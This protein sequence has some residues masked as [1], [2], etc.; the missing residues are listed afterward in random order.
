MGEDRYIPA[1]GWRLLT[2]LFDPVVAVTTRERRWRG[3]VV[4]EALAPSPATILD[5]GCGTGTLA[6]QLA[7]RAPDTRVIGLDGDSDVL[8]RAAAKAQAA[9]VK[10]ELL[11]GMADSIPLA[12]ASIDCAVSTLVFHHLAP[13]T[14]RRA[15]EEI[16][17]VLRPGGRVVIADYGGPHDLLMRVAFLCVQLL[18]G[19]QSTR[20]HAAGE[21]PGLIADAGFEVETIDRLRTLS[22]TLELLTATPS[23]PP[24]KDGMATNATAVSS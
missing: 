5:V 21:L 1:A 12:D 3:K 19:F 6:V 7:G 24:R 20:Q 22:G 16:R 15:L 2:P 14:K 17:R 23:A 9:Q 18:D 11:N 8:Q 13:D 4:D 10:V